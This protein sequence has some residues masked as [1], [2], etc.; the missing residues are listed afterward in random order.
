MNDSTKE[1]PIVFVDIEADAVGGSYVQ[2]AGRVDRDYPGTLIPLKHRSELIA[3]R[4]WVN[5]KRKSTLRTQLIQAK[6]RATRTA[7]ADTHAA[8]DLTPRVNTVPSR[9]PRHVPLPAVETAPPT[10]A[11]SMKFVN[12]KARRPSNRQ[13][14]TLRARMAALAGIAALTPKANPRGSSS[15]S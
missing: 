4:P 3:P 14:N 9:R 8:P 11:F 13:V 5:P 10:K 7:W 1:Q 2:M 15:S 12:P 6:R